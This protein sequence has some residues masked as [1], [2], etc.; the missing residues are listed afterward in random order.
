[1]QIWQCTDC[2]R[3]YSEYVNGCPNHDPDDKTLHRVVL[4]YSELVT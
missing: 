1:M 2:K 4:V 3:T